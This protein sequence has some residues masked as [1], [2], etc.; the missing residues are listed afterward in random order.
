MKITTK[1]KF[2][3]RKKR[4]RFSLKAKADSSRARLSIF[5][6]DKHISAQ[7]IDDRKHTTLI[8]ASTVEKEIRE[9]LK[10][11]SNVTAA[12]L[13]G[14]LVAE[15]ATKAGIKE[16][17]FDRG[18]YAYHGKIKALASSARDAGLVF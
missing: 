8:S 10:S 13:I 5:R 12:E 7:I 11:T 17:Y 4:M 15:R 9:S 3:R 18:G 6:S 2:N 14:K 16:V 1:D